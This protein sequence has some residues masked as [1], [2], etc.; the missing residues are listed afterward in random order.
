MTRSCVLPLAVTSIFFVLFVCLFRFV[1]YFSKPFVMFS[2]TCVVFD[3]S[4]GVALFFSLSVFQKAGKG[5]E[6]YGNS[7]GWCL[8]VGN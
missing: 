3:F 7:G 5:G 6:R 1:R 4:P 8:I 2:L